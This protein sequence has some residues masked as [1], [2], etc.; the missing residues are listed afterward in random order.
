MVARARRAAC[1]TTTPLA[2]CPHYSAEFASTDFPDATF[3][4][5]SLLR[6]NRMG[7]AHADPGAGHHISVQLFAMGMIHDVAPALVGNRLENVSTPNPTGTSISGLSRASPGVRSGRRDSNPRQPAGKNRCRRSA[8]ANA[9]FSLPRRS[10]LGLVNACLQLLSKGQ[11][12][13]RSSEGARWNCHHDGGV[14]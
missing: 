6:H 11:F 8:A 13:V 12:R 5:G 7:T 9:P 3:L 10:F 1:I 14:A 4:A 2:G